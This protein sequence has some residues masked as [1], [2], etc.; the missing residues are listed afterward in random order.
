MDSRFLIV[1]ISWIVA[2]T[3]FEPPASFPLRSSRLPN[4]ISESA[5][6]STPFA[7]REGLEGSVF[8]RRRSRAPGSVASTTALSAVELGNALA[9]AAGVVDAFYRNN[10][11]QAAAV[12]CGVKASLSDRISQ[13]NIEAEHAFCW[14]RNGAFILYGSLYQGVAQHFIFNE[15]YP[16]VFGAGTDVVTVAE[17]VL[18]DQLVLT[19][20]LCLPVAYLVKAAVF[21]RPL[22]EGLNHYISDAKKDLLWKYWLL[23]TPVQCLTFTV[24]PEHLRIPF[25]ALVSFFW[26]I[27]LSNISSRPELS[28]GPGVPA[29]VSGKTLICYDNECL[30]I[31]EIDDAVD[32]PEAFRQ[33]SLQ[34]S[35]QPADTAADSA[36]NGDRGTASATADTTR[37]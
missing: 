7:R 9:A 5:N 27:I 37:V 28:S 32:F 2:V 30:V 8:G 36:V 26:L 23:W 33:P 11:V 17:K 12:T 25:I 21:Q 16:A 4:Q 35:L 31:D 15:I 1:K 3:A 19:P 29:A 24:V 14:S 34:P 6:P 10:P 18:F 20:L 13:R 22:K